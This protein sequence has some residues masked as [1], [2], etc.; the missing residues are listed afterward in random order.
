MRFL[1]VITIIILFVFCVGID[2]Y[3]AWD[4]KSS[5][6][7]RPK[8]WMGIHIGF[9]LLCW[10]LL[11]AIMLFMGNKDRPLFALMWMIYTFLS[12]YT[13]KLLYVIFSALGRLLRLILKNDKC[14]VCGRIVGLALGL[15][16]FIAMWWGA[17][18]TRYKVD[19]EKVTV[20]SDRLPK[21]F[22]GYRIV[23]FSDAHVGS[24]GDD[25][26]FI[27]KLV[28]EINSLKPDL[29]VFTG[30]V[31]NMETSELEPF[32]NVLSKL[33]AR[34]GV[35]SVL[36]NHDYGDYKAWEN[37]SDRETNNALLAIW[38]RQMG[39]NLLNNRHVFL[40]NGTDSIAL[41]GVENW[42]EPPFRQYGDIVKAYHASASGR[43]EN[44]DALKDNN[45]K[46]LLSHNPEHWNRE[47]SV[48]TNVDL[49]LSGHTHAMQTMLRLG[50]WRWSP[51]EWKYQQ[52]GGL[53]E[54]LNDDGEPTRLYV[55]IGS[56]EVGIPARIGA[57]PEI[58][59]I[60]LKCK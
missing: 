6:R 27:S 14:F 54:R 37:P 15:I 33:K 50:N 58:T 34:D 57:T 23:Q 1:P 2:A 8:V 51:A 21:L 36:G 41:I 17:L 30:D 46:I 22:D 28:S 3:I 48:S 16:A 10:G 25:T 60:T 5:V 32:L 55:N 18:V 12:V 47:V 52:W 4:I 19:V 43:P 7:K 59:E 24:W 26:T 44:T 9:S 45:F 35:Y 20:T 56:G 39:W 38:Q 11:L 42:G 53:Y 13:L 29:I 49:T 40:K 31:V